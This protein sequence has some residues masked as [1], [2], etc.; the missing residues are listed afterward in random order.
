MQIKQFIHKFLKYDRE[1]PIF[2]LEK[3]IKFEKI[4]A[5]QHAY[6]S[7]YKN[8]PVPDHSTIMG[9]VS[10]FKT[11]GS[12]LPKH[13]IMKQPREKR[14]EAKMVADSAT[15]SSRKGP[16][17]LANTCLIE[18]HDD[19]HLKAYKHHQWHKLEV[20][21]YEKRVEFAI[22]FLSLAAQVKF[23]FYFSDEA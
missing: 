20:H 21:D 16:R 2:L 14:E 23:F 8:E 11:T 22:W 6:R 9:I 18:L 12:V 1:K 5:V 13:S 19:L 3:Y 10:E 7:K 15:F 17:N 4:S